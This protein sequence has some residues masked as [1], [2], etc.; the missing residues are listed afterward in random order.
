MK[1]LYSTSEYKIK[2]TKRAISRLK[3]SLLSKA[4]KRAR[5]KKLEGLKKEVQKQ[6]RINK[7]FTNKKVYAPHLP[8]LLKMK[9]PYLV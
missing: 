9:K 8:Q 3:S 7:S 2:N 5:R 1:K 6:Q 4:K